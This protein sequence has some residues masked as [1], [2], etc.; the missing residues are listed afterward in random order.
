MHPNF[1]FYILVHFSNRL[2]SHLS[3]FWA[4]LHC[5]AAK[6][7]SGVLNDFQEGG[8][9]VQGA[10]GARNKGD[11]LL[12]RGYCNK[13]LIISLRGTTLGIREAIKKLHD[14]V[15]CGSVRTNIFL[16]HGQKYAKAV[17]IVLYVF[18]LLLLISFRSFLSILIVF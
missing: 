15:A 4:V 1:P 5:L 18:C 7:S 8:V 3:Y 6:S 17:F 16:G 11:A 14:T 2:D 12:T 9:C 13:I 10:V